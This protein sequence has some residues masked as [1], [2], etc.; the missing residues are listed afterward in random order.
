MVENGSKDRQQIINKRSQCGLLLYL[1]TLLLTLLYLAFF[2]LFKRNTILCI[3]D[4]TQNTLPD[5]LNG[6]MNTESE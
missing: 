6:L 3:A 2:K 5:F 1:T 4:I